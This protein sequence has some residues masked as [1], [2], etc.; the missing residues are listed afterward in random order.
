MVSGSW[1]APV[2]PVREGSA[3]QPRGF[4]AAHCPAAI[5]DT[6]APAGDRQ[7]QYQRHQCLQRACGDDYPGVFLGQSKLAT[8]F[9]DW[10]AWVCSMVRLVVVPAVTLLVLWPM[11]EACHEIRMALFLAACA[12]VGSNVAVYAEKQS[13]DAV[14]AS[15]SVCLS[16]LLSVVTMR[17]CWRRPNGSG[18]YK[19]HAAIGAVN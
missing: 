3:A 16:T 6:A 10:R 5:F 14:Y 12:P 17:L 18:K 4:V 13:L 2:R 1:A 15:R 7:R 19:R 11:P 9:T 8:I